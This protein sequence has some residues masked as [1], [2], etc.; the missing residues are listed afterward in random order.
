VAENAEPENETYVYG[1]V[2]TSG[3]RRGEIDID[4][5]PDVHVVWAD[6]IGAVVRPAAADVS[7]PDRRALTSHARVLQQTMAWATVLPMRFGVVMPSDEVVRE[8]LLRAR[9]NEL[10]RLLD[11]F[12]GRVEVTLK[13][14]Y[15]EDVILQEI[16]EE[17]PQ[18][19]RLRE[20][21]RRVPGDAS[22]YD[23]IRLGEMIVGAMRKK[24]DADARRIV[25]TLRPY[26]VD[27]SIDETFV[28]RVALRGAFLVE[29]SRLNEFD[30]A[31]E[32]LSRDLAAR[33][34]FKYV[35]PLPPHSF[36]DLAVGGPNRSTA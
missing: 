18:I 2:R 12:E 7:K 13:A 28:E 11:A 30:A 8:E 27:V 24:R 34:R 20:T 10:V 19:A 31:V 33:I 1:V 22:F 26:A 14:F 17:N 29:E 6:E 35:G 5:V 25:A 23:R 21:V 36:V 15:D 9:R 32:G 4:E 3:P 16:V